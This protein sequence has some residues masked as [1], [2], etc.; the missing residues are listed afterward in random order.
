MK[1][2]APARPGQPAGKGWRDGAD[3]GGP[4]Y[5]WQ[6]SAADAGWAA[7]QR[8]TSPETGGTTSA[9]LPMRVPQAHLMPG[10]AESGE[11]PQ[12][13]PAAFRSADEVRGRLSSYQQGVRRGRSAD[14]TG[15]P[16]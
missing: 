12:H 10:A 1:F 16:Q 5:E 2:G 4:A 6:P 14:S 11:R 3:M 8:L 9:G 13:P 7:A 15:E